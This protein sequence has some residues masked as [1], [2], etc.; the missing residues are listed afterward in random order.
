M[1]AVVH[2]NRVTGTA[3]SPTSTDITNINT[4]AR[5]DDVHSQS[6]TT[7]PVKVPTSGTNYSFWVSTRLEVISGITG[8]IDNLKWY[9]AGGPMASGISILGMNAT[10]YVQ[11]TGTVGTTGIQLTT[12]NHAGLTATPVDVFG[13]TSG[14]PKSLSGSTTGVGA[15]GDYFV[16]QFGVTNAA[17]PGATSQPTFT[18]QYDET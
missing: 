13:F 5:S 15:F 1:A 2:V 8:T 9:A 14:A 17:V 4:R 16:Y 3:G 6:G 10:S 11:A 12:G 7:N 18:W